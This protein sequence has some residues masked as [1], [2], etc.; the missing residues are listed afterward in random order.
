MMS[1]SRVLDNKE[2]PGGCSMTGA[3]QNSPLIA[4][5]YSNIIATTL[6]ARYFVQKYGENAEFIGINEHFQT[7]IGQ[8]SK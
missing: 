8:S 1:Y 3:Y 5:Q 6:I 7:A 4:H 2:L